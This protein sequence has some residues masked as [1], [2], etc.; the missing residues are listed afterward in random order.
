[1]ASRSGHCA[2]VLVVGICALLAPVGIAAGRWILGGTPW[3]L[4]ALVIAL[5]P[6]TWMLILVG[7]MRIGWIQE[8]PPT[9]R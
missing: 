8:N 6:A 4:F 7:L 3:W 1:M 5:N 2:V 9:E